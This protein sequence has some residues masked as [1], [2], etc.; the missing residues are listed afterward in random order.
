VTIRNANPFP[1][2]FELEFAQRG[3]RVFSKLPGGLVSKPGK[4]IWATTLP[5]NGE[6]KIGYDVRDVEDAE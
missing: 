1:V 5:A 2:R 6:Q 3:S 4:R